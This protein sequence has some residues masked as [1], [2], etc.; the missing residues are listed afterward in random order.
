VSEKEEKH[1]TDRNILP[2]YVNQVKVLELMKSIYCLGLLNPIIVVKRE[3]E[4]G[5]EEARLVAGLH[6]LQA[7][8]QLA[9]A[10]DSSISAREGRRARRRVCK[11]K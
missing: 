10:R 11:E 9:R 6:R 8:K 2:D 7:V 3:R 4:D 1:M 5:G